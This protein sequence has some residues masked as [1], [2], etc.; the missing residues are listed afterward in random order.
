MR[1][2]VAVMWSDHQEYLVKKPR[3]E[4]NPPRLCVYGDKPTL[5]S[6]PEA[7]SYLDHVL[8]LNYPAY[9]RAAAD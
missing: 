5:F 6:E 9:M 8:A 2:V 7:K 4:R 1:Y 3:C